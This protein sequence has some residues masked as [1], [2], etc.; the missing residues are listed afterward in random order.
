MFHKCTLT[1]RLLSLSRH[2]DKLPS[3]TKSWVC[4]LCGNAKHRQ[5][6]QNTIDVPQIQCLEPLEEV[7]VV[8]QQMAEIPVVMPKQV[9]TFQKIQKPANDPQV[10]YCDKVVEGPVVMQRPV[11]SV[12]TA[13]KITKVSHIDTDK[14]VSQR[15]IISSAADTFGRRHVSTTSRTM[16]SP[17]TWKTP[18]SWSNTIKSRERLPSLT[19]LWTCRSSCEDSFPWSI[20]CRRRWKLHESS[21]STES[22]MF[23]WWHKDMFLPCHKSSENGGSATDSARW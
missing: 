4:Q 18:K 7:P 1:N 14:Q 10:Q 5:T 2:R 16:H 9:R 19:M 11:P 13:Q 21:S 20:R 3:L 15:E 8:T 22:W 23:P 17:A 12:Q 6:E